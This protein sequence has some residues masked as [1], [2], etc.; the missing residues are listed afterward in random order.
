MEKAVAHIRSLGK[1]FWHSK[2]MLVHILWGLVWAWILREVW[3]EFNIKWII[4]SIVGSWV[5]DLDH[6]LYWFVYGRH[7]D[8]SR[9]VKAIIKKGQIRTLIIFFEKNHK[10]NTNLMM[11]NIYFLGLLIIITFFAY[12]F[13]RRSSLVLFGAMV[14]HYLYDLVDDLLI[15]G[16]LNSNWKRLGNGAKKS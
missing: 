11:H 14:T 4:L 6:L 3:N 9:K 7:D 15:L 12:F 2:H 13:D 1:T 10:S 16:H 5:P 8:Y